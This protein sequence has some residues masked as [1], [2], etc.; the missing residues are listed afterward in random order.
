MRI[1]DWSSDVCSSDLDVLQP[2]AGIEHRV[3]DV[4]HQI[5]DDEHEYDDHQIGH[6]HR[7]IEDIDRI[8]DQLAHA[9]PGEDG[10]RH[11]GEGDHA[12]ELQPE[13]GDHRDQDVLQAIGRES[14]RERVCQ[15]V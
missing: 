3:E 12:A 11:H 2:D 14:C 10:L 6:D 13:H 7:P 5:D 1:S 9:G 15:Y 4:D 8:D